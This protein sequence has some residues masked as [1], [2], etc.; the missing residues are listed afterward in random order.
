[1]SDADRA[2]AE[3]IA[4]HVR[5]CDGRRGGWFEVRALMGRFDVDRF[6]SAA[7]KRM[8]A[9]LTEAELE[10]SAPL[11][12]LDRS[13]TVV[14]T[15]RSAPVDPPAPMHVAALDSAL[16]VRLAHDGQLRRVKLHDVP[17]T[18]GAVRWFDIADS[19]GLHPD[20][21]LER[22]G[23][24][25]AGELTA[26]MVEDLLSPDPRPGVKE[27]APGVRCV[28]AFAVEA[29]ESDAGAAADSC[30]KAGVLVFQPVEF[31]VGS[32][33]LIT[34]WH[35]IEIFRGADRIEERPPEPPPRVFAEVE[36]C[37]PHAGL[38]SA[39]DVALLVL[40]ELCLTYAP[41]YRRLY[42]WQEEWELDFYRRPK[43]LDADT[44]LEVRAAAAVLRD[45]LAPLNPSGMRED[46]GKAW[47]PGITGTAEEGG[48]KKALRIDDR[49]D[50]AL[51][52]I[53][54]FADTLRS[55]YDLQQLRT[56]ERE[57]DRDDRFQ[58]NV[59]VGGS[60]LLF[61]ALVV[62]LMGANTWVPGQYGDD[63]P[64]WAFVVLL[65]VVAVAAAVAW[66]GIRLLQRRDERQT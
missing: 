5:S 55:S 21:V 16:T 33:W 29:R 60:V 28:S 41:A 12:E 40:A 1:M 43:R 66:F 14:L 37:W 26:P 13:D 44:L 58:R 9:A 64:H 35:D 52:N 8:T 18:T 4:E 31:L 59:A 62:G 54:R 27:P 49:I 42:V 3:A 39:G 63:A 51:D 32:G 2:A 15:L 30:S 48:Y 10:L 24:Y 38:S 17:P 57:R 45:W 25:C 23:P 6:S 50:S 36:R 34:C 7:Q 11:S 56:S 65:V 20:V 22:L 46:V 47:F 19:A 61:P 53:R